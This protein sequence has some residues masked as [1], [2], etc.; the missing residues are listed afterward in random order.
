MK[1]EKSNI[2][3]EKKGVLR[4]F[5]RSFKPISHT[6]NAS[7]KFIKSSYKQKY[8]KITSCLGNAKKNVSVF[9]FFLAFV[10]D[11]FVYFCVF[12]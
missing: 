4:S 7:L 11:L 3:Q 2:V 9:L 1:I 8:Y 5:E 10:F 6:R 12:V